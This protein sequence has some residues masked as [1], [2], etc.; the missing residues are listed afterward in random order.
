MW[1]SS[2]AI[3]PQ[4][5]QGR[6]LLTNRQ[7]MH[8]AVLQAF[9]PHALEG[10]GERV[11]W[12]LDQ[13]NHAHTLYVVSPLEPD[14]THIV[15][16]AG[17]ISQTWNSISYDSLL[18]KLVVGQQWGFRLQANPVKREFV[19]GGRG[20]VLPH[21]TPVQQAQWLLD[22]AERLGFSIPEETDGAPAVAVTH[23][24][25]LQFGRRDENLGGRS[26]QVTLRNVQFD[27]VL[28]VTDA[29]ALRDALVQGIGKGK[30]YG[31]GLMTL[32]RLSS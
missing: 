16:N 21:V 17:W 19:K 31:C 20:K 8:K 2:I 27:G 3:N 12:R 10:S 28:Q 25:D 15:E 24:T 6:V 32:R 30:A 1:F 18:G 5:R 9:P 13:E 11:L 7:K 29:S 14:F 22:R 4:K 26:R 23:R